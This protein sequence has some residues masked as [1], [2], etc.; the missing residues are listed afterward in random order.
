MSEETKYP[1]VRKACPN[2]SDWPEW[3]L[4]SI[5]LIMRM[6]RMLE[7]DQVQDSV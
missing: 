6:E 7:R 5:G 4:D 1:L 2:L 3:K